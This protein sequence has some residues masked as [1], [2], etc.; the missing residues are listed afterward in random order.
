MTLDFYVL[1]PWPCN[2][3]DACGRVDDLTLRSVKSVMPMV[4]LDDGDVHDV[5]EDKSVRIARDAG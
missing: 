3:R 5:V 1:V 4:T 2:V